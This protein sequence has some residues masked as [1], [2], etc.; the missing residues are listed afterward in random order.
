LAAIP[1]QPVIN[2]DPGQLLGLDRAG[3]TA[4]LGEPSLVRRDDPAEIWQYVGS[5][6][7]FDVVLYARGQDYSVTYTEARDAAAA[8]Q[9]PRPCLNSLLR[10]RQAAPVS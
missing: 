8:L 1:P 7:V 3:V 4:L 5:G 10:E 9:A 2:D 6:C